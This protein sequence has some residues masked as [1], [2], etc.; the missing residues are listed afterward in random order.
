MEIAIGPDFGLK[1]TFLV[2]TI[3]RGLKPMANE[4]R[5]LVSRFRFPVSRLQTSFQ[6]PIY[7]S[8]RNRNRFPVLAV[9][10][11][12]YE[13]AETEVSP[14]YF[15]PDFRFPIS[16][17][18]CYNLKIL[19]T[20]PYCSTPDTFLNSSNKSLVVAG[21]NGNRCPSNKARKAALIFASPISKYNSYIFTKPLL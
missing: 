2:W 15:S 7:D 6:F 9:F 5:S 4:E 20:S 21:P 11:K 17:L 16:G 3:S 14:P 18:P 19:S 12:K 10:K 1:P 13:Q 8:Y